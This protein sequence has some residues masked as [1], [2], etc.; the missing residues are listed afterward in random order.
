MPGPF[1]VL[2]HRVYLDELYGVTV[3]WLAWFSAQV[4]NWMDRWV[5]N[6]AVQAAA[7]MVAGLA[8]IDSS[9]DTAVINTGFDSGCDGVSRGGLLVTRVQ[10][11]RVQSYL[12]VLG[13]AL[14]ALV[15]FLFWSH[16]G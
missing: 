1:H 10:S 14:V 12:R 4:M 11:G 3:V 13:I 2:A 6:G 15:L 16:K 7:K 9:L 8:W 5:W